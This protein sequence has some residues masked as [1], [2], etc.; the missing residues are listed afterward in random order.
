MA[1]NAQRGTGETHV[2]TFHAPLVTEARSYGAALERLLSAQKSAAGVPAYLRWVN[3]PLGR[4][5]AALAYVARLTPNQ[6]TMLSMAVSAVGIA[7]LVLV[8]PTLPAALIAC[9]A[10]LLGYALDS[11]DGQLARLTGSSGP[12]GEYLDHVADAVR[13]PATHLAIAASLYLRSDLTAEWP[14]LV[15]IGFATVTS[16]WFFAQILAA[17]LLPKRAVPLGSAAPPW[18]SFVK[19]PYDVGFLYLLLLLLPWAWTFVTLYVAL[20]VFTVGVASLSMWRKYQALHDSSS[21]S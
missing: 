9:L 19:I 13:Q 4:R 12:S 6:V 17:S 8:S 7:V 15:A 14:V 2:D 20:F 3:R 1:T 10:M 5:L 21:F 16:V 18:V 11:A